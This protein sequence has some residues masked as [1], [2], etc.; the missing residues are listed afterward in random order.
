MRA[1]GSAERHGGGGARLAHAHR[2]DRWA[3]ELHGVVHGEQGGH[4]AARR[5]D[6][7]VHRALHVLALEVQQLGD[8]QVGDVL[9][10]RGAQEHDALPQQPGVDV[11]G[12]FAPVGGL[13]DGGDEHCPV[14]PYVQPSGCAFER[15]G[16]RREAQL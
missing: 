15:K 1:L 11:V 2:V 13:D 8:D 4:V 5:V 12:P 16:G 3:H 7:E 9:V 6:V 14:P 10:E